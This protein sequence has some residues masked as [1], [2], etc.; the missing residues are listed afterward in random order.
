M[1]LPRQNFFIADASAG[2]S[3]KAII[4]ATE[5]LVG[6]KQIH[7]LHDLGGFKFLVG[8]KSASAVRKFRE[9]GSLRIAGEVVPVDPAVS[10]E[11]NTSV[12][13][14]SLPTF[15]GDEEIVQALAPYGKVLKIEAARYGDKRSFLTGPRYIQLRM[16]TNNPLPY[17]LR[18]SGHRVTFNYQEWR[19]DGRRESRRP[20][21]Q[22]GGVQEG[23]SG[24]TAQAK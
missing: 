14:W 11:V 12:T 6:V 2:V 3:A 22:D 20:G 5:A 21:S 1:V 9:A 15:V 18:I 13:C 7:S 23:P 4:A 19:Q 8:L 10:D 17:C 16:K 24:A